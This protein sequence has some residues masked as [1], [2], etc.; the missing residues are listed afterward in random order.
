VLTH[1]S[2]NW[3]LNKCERIK[4]ETTEIC[5]MRIVSG[6]NY[7]DDVRSKT[8]RISLQ[9][10]ASE[11]GN[12]DYRNKWRNRNLRMDPSKLTNQTGEEMLDD[13]EEDGRMNFEMERVNKSVLRSRCL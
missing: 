13:Q 6:Y 2:E 4:N 10:Y 11:E 8:M 1:G 3:T 9:I 12:Q 5:F 7:T